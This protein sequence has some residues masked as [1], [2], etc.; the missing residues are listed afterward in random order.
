MPDLTID[1][2]ARA[3]WIAWIGT[4]S[5]MECAVLHRF[6]EPGAALFVEADLQ[7]VFEKRFAEVGGMTPG[8]SKA[9]GWNKPERLPHPRDLYQQVVDSLGGEDHR[10]TVTKRTPGHAHTRIEGTCGPKVTL[11]KIKATFFHP[12]FGGREASVF[13]GKFSVI[14]H[15]D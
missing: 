4:L 1:G 14:R 12:M 11:D 2:V 15:T 9:I 6:S 7:P 8:V 10:I 3:D 5:Q 13:G